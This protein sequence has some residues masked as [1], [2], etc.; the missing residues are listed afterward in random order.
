MELN[1]DEFKALRS[2]VEEVS[3]ELEKKDAA[4]AV[5]TKWMA[6]VGAIIVAALGYT[7]FVQLPAEA[8]KAAKEQVGPEIV[9]E[10]N[11]I[12][13]EL[14]TNGD[15]AEEIVKNLRESAES[16]VPIPTGTIIAWHPTKKDIEM[17]GGIKITAPEGWAVCDGKNGTPDLR[18]QFLRGLPSEVSAA[19]FLENLARRAGQA[20]HD[21]GPHKHKLVG[22]G[23]MPVT[24]GETLRNETTVAPA[25]KVS[26]LPPYVNVVY[27]MRLGQ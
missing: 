10:A 24:T 1:D 2:R 6:T 9:E 11:K 3:A 21:H 19:D 26:H 27:I 12:V 4:R 20:E 13:E 17:Q 14:R 25:V 16:V 22:P 15:D 5:N 7:N 18:G 23:R 8:S